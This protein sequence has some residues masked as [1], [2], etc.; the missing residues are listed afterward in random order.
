[1][2]LAWGACGGSVVEVWA[3]EAHC[4]RVATGVGCKCARRLGLRA[5][6]VE[7]ARGS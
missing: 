1:V 2:F 3:R 6:V 5:G 7:G 4:G